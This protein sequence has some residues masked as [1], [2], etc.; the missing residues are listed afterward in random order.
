MI[1][2]AVKEAMKKGLRQLG[3]V[4]HKAEVSPDP[5]FV[6]S[7]LIRASEPVIFDVGAHVGITAKTYRRLFPTA[8]IYCFEPFAQSFEKLSRKMEGDAHSHIHK[9]A[10]SDKKGKGVLNSNLSS[11]TNSLLPTDKRGALYWGEG[12]LDT[13]DEVEVTTTTIDAFCH[14]ND[15]TKID[16]LKMDVQGAEYSV[17]MGAKDML[18]RQRVSLIYTE[19]IICPSYAGQHKLQEYL[20]L[21]DS[22]GYDFYDLYNPVRRNHQLIQADLVFL[23]TSFRKTVPVIC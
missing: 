14:E 1:I 18:A 16:I 3:Y 4:I 5:F 7:Q 6:Q 13:K 19:L 15:I 9:V 11:A 17:L 23:S 8:A 22:L 2:S 12:L 10:L 20:V 21:L